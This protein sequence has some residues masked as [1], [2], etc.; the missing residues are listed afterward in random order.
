LKRPLLIS[1]VFLFC[2]VIKIQ[3]QSDF[4]P[5]YIITN[6]FETIEGH[7][8]YRGEIR[9][10]NICS[11]KVNKDSEVI[12]YMP[13]DIFG[14]RYN[15]GKYYISKEIPF[16]D[17]TEIVFL[18]YI[19]DGIANLYYYREANGVHYYIEKDD[20]R[21]TE[22]TNDLKYYQINGEK[23]IS[24]PTQRYIGVLR[25]ALSDCN[26]IQP[27]I[28]KAKFTHKSLAVIV[29][30]YHNFVCQEGDVCINYQK[31]L[32]RTEFGI[33]ITLGGQSGTLSYVDQ[34]GW[35]E[36]VY[37]DF[38]NT[39]G[40]YPVFGLSLEIMSPRIS[41]RITFN[42]NI[43]FGKVEYSGKSE[44][45]IGTMVIYNEMYKTS[46]FLTGTIIINYNFPTGK[47]KPFIGIGPGLQLLLNDESLR[48]YQSVISGIPERYEEYDDVPYSKSAFQLKSQIGVR[49]D[50]AG[51]FSPY[52]AL[53][54]DIGL[55]N[56]KSTESADDAFIS[57]KYQTI[58]VVLGIYYN[59]R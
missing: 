39:S 51:L 18:E 21:L 32:E 53:S 4:I 11:F 13:G 54:Y 28:D 20:I 46:T 40:F 5:G 17:T 22:L 1:I 23:E 59:F 10:S 37:S 35:F 19:V 27:D 43:E 7:V 55:A 49:L 34:K 47:I 41:N 2:I 29:E 58:G 15:N 16:G 57:H 6:D 3:A 52:A 36:G 48:T 44:E 56:T 30:D 42:T 38:K 14:Y 33:G 50:N 12:D 8:D 25:A 24:R 31:E 45:N 26:E 9:N